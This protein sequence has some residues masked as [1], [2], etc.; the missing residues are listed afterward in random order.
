MKQVVN[1]SETKSHAD[2]ISADKLIVQSIAKMDTVAFGIAVGSVFGLII[3]FATN[4]LIFKGG[5]SVGQT[6]GRLNQY[7]FAY[8]VNFAGSFLGFFYGFV[9]GFILGWLT[10]F[11]RNLFIKL[12]I[13]IAKFKERMTTLNN[14]L[15]L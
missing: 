6:L 8:K 5:E 3:F 1:S 2:C 7:F 10:A 4:L 14:F 13:Y 9:L 12:F 11:L 15:D